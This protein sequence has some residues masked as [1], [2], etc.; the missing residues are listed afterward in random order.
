[1][2]LSKWSY[3]SLQI[4]TPNSAVRL[5]REVAANASLLPDAFARINRLCPI[6]TGP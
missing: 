3:G 5:L 6:W 1:M 4:T 2:G